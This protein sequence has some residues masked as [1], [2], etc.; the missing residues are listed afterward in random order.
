[1]SRDAIARYLAVGQPR[2][3]AL[4]RSLVFNPS[5]VD[6]MEFADIPQAEGDRDSLPPPRVAVA[7]KK[8]RATTDAPKKSKA[9]WI[10]VG[11]L[12]VLLGGGAAL[13]L[14]PYGPFGMNLLEPF[15]P[16]AGDPA[17]VEA[18]ISAAATRATRSERVPFMATSL[19]QRRA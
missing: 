10:A 7:G 3:R 18:A 8:A 2:L 1:M 19:A 12:V 15:M 9:A 6:D 11:I 4:I 5:D 17:Q 16:G 13:G 14:T